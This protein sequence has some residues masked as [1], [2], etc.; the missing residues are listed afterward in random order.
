MHVHTVRE[1]VEEED[2]DG[3]DGGGGD[4]NGND[5]DGA[6]SL[7]KYTCPAVLCGTPKGTKLSIF[8]LS[9]FSAFILA[10]QIISQTHT[11]KHINRWPILFWHFIFVPFHF[12]L[13]LYSALSSS[14]WSCDDDRCV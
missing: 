4:G 9:V 7:P 3:G 10:D 8:F 12:F 2:G 1:E 13:L 5:D 6:P 11:G 14:L